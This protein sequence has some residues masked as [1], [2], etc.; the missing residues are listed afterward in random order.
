MLNS[1]LSIHWMYVSVIKTYKTVSTSKP[2]GLN[3]SKKTL[4][5]HIKVRKWIVV[6][7]RLDRI[8]RPNRI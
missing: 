3:I 6:L 5:F 8:Y 2:I 1:I 7:T 4:I